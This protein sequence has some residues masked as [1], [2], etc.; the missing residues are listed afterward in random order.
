[1]E[2]TRSDESIQSVFEY[3][4]I[5]ETENH[6]D[7]PIILDGNGVLRW[8]ANPTVEMVFELS[9]LDLNKLIT[10]LDGKNSEEYRRLYR[11]LGYSLSGYWEVFYWDLNNEDWYKYRNAEIIYQKARNHKQVR[12]TGG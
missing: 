4:I 9:C 12:S 2:I 8:Q 11:D 10:K 3:K 7:H 1:M 5:V 6:H